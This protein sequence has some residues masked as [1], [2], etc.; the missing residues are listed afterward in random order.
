MCTLIIVHE[1]ELDATYV[2]LSVSLFLVVCSTLAH[3]L[4][5]LYRKYKTASIPA[6][7]YQNWQDTIKNMYVAVVLAQGCEAENF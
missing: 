1:G 4:F 7:H 3:V 5:F 6:Q 2:H